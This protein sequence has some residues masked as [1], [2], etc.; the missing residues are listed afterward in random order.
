M[1]MMKIW[2]FKS[3]RLRWADHIVK[4]EEGRRVSKV[5]I[6]KTTGRDLYEGVGK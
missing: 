6:G 4:V 5:I 2:M 1:E 3:R